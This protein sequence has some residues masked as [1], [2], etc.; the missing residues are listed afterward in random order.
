MSVKEK[1]EFMFTN[2]ATKCRFLLRN[3]TIEPIFFIFAFDIGIFGIASGELYIQK[4]CRVNLNYTDE[5]CDNIYAHKDKQ[6]T[7]QEFVTDLQRTSKIIQAVPP[8]IYALFA[9]PWSDK[10]GRKPLIILGIFGYVISNIV[11]LVNTHWFYKLKAEYLLLECLQ[12]KCYT[13]LLTII[14]NGHH[15]YHFPTAYIII[16]RSFF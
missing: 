7:N 10:H 5:V 6:E 9:G 13:M 1:C 14:L 3:I 4:M 12:G 11:F 16:F 2:I 15:N 8:L